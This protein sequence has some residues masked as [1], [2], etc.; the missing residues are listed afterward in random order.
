MSLQVLAV[1]VGVSLAAPLVHA[2]NIDSITIVE[3]ASD[4]GVPRYGKVEA[5]V[6]LS[7]V[8]ATKFYEPNPAL[9]GLGLNATFT[10]PGGARTRVNGYYD[11]ANWRVRFSPGR[12][13]KWSFSVSATDGGGTDTRG[14]EAF[15]CVASKH[16]GF[17]KVSGQYLKFTNRQTFF[18][19]GHNNG[20]QYDVEQP[21]LA[22]MA[23]QGE[24]LLSFWMATPWII[25]SDNI[26]R[27]PIENTTEG[28]GNYNQ[29][30][31]AYIDGV[32][33]RAEAT[34]VYLLP[35]IWAHD[36]LCDGRPPDWPA[37]WSNN[38]YS[39]VC[40]AQDFYTT[41][42][43]ND[44]EQ[45]RY[46]KNFYRYLLAR[47]GHS[48]AIVGWVG[49]VEIEGTTGYA[50]NNS[51]T[52]TWAEKLRAFFAS[53]D[54]YRTRRG[55]YP[56]TIS[57]SDAPTY[58]PGVDMHATDSYDSKSKDSAVAATIAVQTAIERALGKPAFHTEFGGDVLAG[59][60]QPAHLHNGIWAGVSNGAALTPLL[61]CDGGSFPMLTDPN[62][63]AAM[64]NQLRIL[65]EF[66]SGISYLGD[67]KVASI[68]PAFS[69][70]ALR[71][72]GMGVRNKAFVWIQ[73]S[74]GGYINGQTMTFSGLAAGRYTAA[75]YDTWSSGVMPVFT[76][77][78]IEVKH[79]GLFSVM[80][81]LLS[82]PDLAVSIFRAH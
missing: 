31:C 33:S 74:Q 1:L 45:W 69:D 3:P 26:P 73:N 66:I 76:V 71:G 46:Q 53:N 59:A 19:I 56:L 12:I 11:G 81:P 20:W 32:V 75:F 82:R 23:A 80:L 72:W 6:V 57:R 54:V 68:A 29:A 37:S 58:A 13:G 10:A 42:T 70:A 67:P 16:P 62:V 18:G 78:S 30:S 7:G 39:A 22:D 9:G 44:T 48:R 38:A 77:S 40:G 25:P 28:I 60:S 15:K 8:S 17:A 55:L 36:Q 61:W 79:G 21:P 64:R 65:S 34:N 2:L 51:A 41:G 24:N 63:G 5:L 49:V 14:G 43:T 4:M 35:S 52:S 47:W 27:T 50:L